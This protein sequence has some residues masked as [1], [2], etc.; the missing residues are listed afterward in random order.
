MDFLQQ[1][2]VMALMAVVLI[3]L[4]VLFFVMRKKQSDDE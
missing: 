4:I 1:T 3:G 2:W